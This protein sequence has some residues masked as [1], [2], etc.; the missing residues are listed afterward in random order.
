MDR[1][2]EDGTALTRLPYPLLVD[3]KGMI[4]DQDFWRGNLLWVVGFARD[5]DVWRIDLRVRDFIK[6]P[7]AA[8]GMYL[9]TGNDKGMWYSHLSAVQEARYWGFKTTPVEEGTM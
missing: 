9:V 5:L 2:L 6:K 1:V 8:V 4:Q 3:A 7:E